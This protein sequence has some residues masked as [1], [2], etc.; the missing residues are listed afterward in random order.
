MAQIG[1]RLILASASP[2]RREL[3]A[4]A[5]LTF[6]VDAA[7]ADESVAPGETPAA[8]VDRVA[9]AKATIGAA[10]HPD[11]AVIAGDTTV[12]VDGEILGKPVDD[13]DARRMLRKL[14]G[15]SHQVL[16]AVA[17]A[18]QG[19]VH[20]TVETTK[21]WVRELA[22]ADIEWYVGSGEPRDRAGAYAIQGLFSRFVPRIDGSY[23]NVVGLPVTAV[24]ALLQEAGIAPDR[25][26]APGPSGLPQAVPA[27][28][29]SR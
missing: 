3:L 28:Y 7:D 22:I 4:A 12:V 2:R 26:A 27:P 20:S 5:G 18:W 25:V 19:S 24:L 8:Y 11:A 23:A 29:P 1:P 21:V 15:R 17:L 10:R 6:D 9:R 14:S 16:T 13:D